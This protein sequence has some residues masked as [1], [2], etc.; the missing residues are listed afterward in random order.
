MIIILEKKLY[1]STQLFK[2]NE[3]VIN[4]FLV[5]FKYI[6]KIIHMSTRIRKYIFLILNSTTKKK[7]PFVGINGHLYFIRTY[8]Y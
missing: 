5:E 3:H 4:F 7:L 8:I 1:H 2:T 6:K